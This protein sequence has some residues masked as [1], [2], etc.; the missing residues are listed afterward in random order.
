MTPDYL[1]ELLNAGRV[2]DLAVNPDA[3][4][5]TVQS[6]VSVSGVL[7]PLYP[8]SRISLDVT[9]SAAGGYLRNPTI[10]HHA[11]TGAMRAILDRVLAHGPPPNTLK[12]L[13]FSPQ[14]YTVHN[15]EDPP[16]R[17]FNLH[18]RPCK[19]WFLALV[20][21]QLVLGE[22]LG[23]MRV[24]RPVEHGPHIAYPVV[25]RTKWRALT[26]QKVIKRLKEEYNKWTTLHS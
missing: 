8:D 19:S 5:R 17:I 9:F 26:N 6:K 21:Y 4:R 13:N 10:N 20:D 7:V 1:D 23:R 25:I 16:A 3:S 18:T 12:Y 22:S 11:L 15:S 2:L 24:F 14:D